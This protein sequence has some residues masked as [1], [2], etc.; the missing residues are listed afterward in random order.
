MAPEPSV[1]I[2]SLNDFVF[3]H[4]SFTLHTQVTPKKL[5]LA[6]SSLLIAASTYPVVHLTFPVHYLSG[7][8]I[9][10]VPHQAHDSPFNPNNSTLPPGFPISITKIITH[11]GAHNR[12]QRVFLDISLLPSTSDEIIYLLLFISPF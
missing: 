11:I 8:S 1:F 12:N 9:Q 7:R 5:S 2:L 6:H 10:Y 3:P 4:G